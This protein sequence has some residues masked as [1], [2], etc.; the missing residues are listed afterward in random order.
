MNIH[1]LAFLWSN[2]ELGFSIDM[3]LGPVPD[4]MI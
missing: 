2:L 1:I 3:G 4:L